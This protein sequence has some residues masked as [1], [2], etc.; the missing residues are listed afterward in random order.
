M[1]HGFGNS[2]HRNHFCNSTHSKP[3][4]EKCCRHQTLSK[5]KTTLWWLARMKYFC[6]SLVTAKTLIF[7][8]GNQGKE[9]VKTKLEQDWYLQGWTKFTLQNLVLHARYL[10]ARLGNV[11]SICTSDWETTRKHKFCYLLHK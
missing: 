1:G 5:I 7:L 10:R 11:K 9:A 3:I 8:F 2:F 6:V 4:I